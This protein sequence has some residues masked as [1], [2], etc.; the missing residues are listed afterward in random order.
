MVAALLRGWRLALMALL[1]V[2]VLAPVSVAA[3]QEIVDPNRVPP[4]RDSVRIAN[5]LAATPPM[6][7]NSWNKFACNIDEKIIRS[8]ADA[9]VANGMRNAG[10]RYVVI[11]DCWHGARDATGAITWNAERFPSGM[12]ALADYIHARA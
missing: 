6:G 7:W 4:S 2:P 10:Y 3:A 1:L 9:M 11:D 8:V 5:G 12:K